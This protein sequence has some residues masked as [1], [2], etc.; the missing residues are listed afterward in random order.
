[1]IAHVVLFRPK[2]QLSADERAT[3][4]AALEYALRN[5]TT[6]K[7]AR[8]GRRVTLGREYDQQNVENYPFAAILEFEDEAGLRAYLDDPAHQALG[9]QFYITAESAMVFDYE[10][11]DAARAN[12]LLA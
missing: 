2:A 4:V 11:L 9:A 8:I 6:I 1:M 12:E 5:I 7:R 3:F 10:L